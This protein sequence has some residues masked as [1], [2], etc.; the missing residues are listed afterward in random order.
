MQKRQKKKNEFNNLKVK[1]KK[2][3]LKP[4][5]YLANIKKKETG[6]HVRERGNERDKHVSYSTLN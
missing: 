6:F 5:V 4:F 2:Y 1:E 3:F